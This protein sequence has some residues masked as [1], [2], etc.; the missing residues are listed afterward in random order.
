M[1]KSGFLM[2]KA[3]KSAPHLNDSKPSGIFSRVTEIRPLVSKTRLFFRTTKF[4]LSVKL[5]LFF[6]K[7]VHYW[8]WREEKTDEKFWRGARVYQQTSLLEIGWRVKCK[9]SFWCEKK[10]E[11][12][13]ILVFLRNFHSQRR[14]LHSPKTNYLC[15][16]R[17]FCSCQ[18]Q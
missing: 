3:L 6:F 5:S 9:I 1:R 13:C 4:R 14:F 15:P 12:D 8:I 7:Q 18:I 16:T 17:V 10:W 2:L 11:N